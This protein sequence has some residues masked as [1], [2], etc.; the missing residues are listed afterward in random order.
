MAMS[1]VRIDVILYHG[2]TEN[3]EKSLTAEDAEDAEEQRE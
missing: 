1:I 3:T 2:G